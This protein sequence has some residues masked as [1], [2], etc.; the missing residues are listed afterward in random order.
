MSTISDPN[1]SIPDMGEDIS[2]G[3]SVSTN[4]VNE[5]EEIL[6]YAIVAPKVQVQEDA[7]NVKELNLDIQQTE[8]SESDLSH[9]SSVHSSNKV[10]ENVLLKMNRQTSNM[11]IKTKQ[12]HFDTQR[13]NAM[14]TLLG[15]LLFLFY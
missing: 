12:L 3:S 9:L 5:Y 2:R 10:T 14:D 6:K 11:N 7:Y 1:G 8:S 13:N 4:F 15:N